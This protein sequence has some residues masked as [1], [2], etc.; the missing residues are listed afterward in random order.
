MRECLAATLPV[1]TYTQ[2]GPAD[3]VFIHVL[4]SVQ[5]RISDYES[6]LGRHVHTELQ[7][8]ISNFS[9]LSSVR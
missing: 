9:Y 1:S 8:Y 4:P 3:A 2:T 7:V 5:S 6:A